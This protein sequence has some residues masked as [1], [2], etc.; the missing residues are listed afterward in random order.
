MEY[1]HNTLAILLRRWQPSGTVD[2]S[3]CK[4]FSLSS[5]SWLDAIIIQGFANMSSYAVWSENNHTNTIKMI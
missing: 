3:R 5:D 2:C 1:I 4:G